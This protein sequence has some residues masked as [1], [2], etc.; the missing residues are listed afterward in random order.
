[1]QHPTILYVG[2]EKR[3]QSFAMWAE[4]RGW[5]VH[6]PQEAMQALGLYVTYWPDITIIDA[7]AHPEVADEVYFHLR[8]IHAQPLLVLTHDLNWDADEDVFTASPAMN[9]YELIETV[10][11]LLDV[12][13]VPMF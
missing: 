12:Q 8:S 5:L 11:D 6:L 13:P 2:D 10:G 3:G 9:N 7:E 1:M 4:E